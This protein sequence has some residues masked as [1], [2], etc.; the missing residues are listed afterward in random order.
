MPYSNIFFPD[1]ISNKIGNLTKNWINDINKIQHE[2]LSMVCK[3]KRMYMRRMWA[4]WAFV[5]LACI[6]Y[7]IYVKLW[8]QSI[9]LVLKSPTNPKQFRL[10]KSDHFIGCVCVFDWF[11]CQTWYIVGIF[12][13]RFWNPGEKMFTFTILHENHHHHFVHHV[14]KISSCQLLPI[15]AQ[16]YT[17]FFVH[18]PV[19]WK[20]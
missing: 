4:G 10:S 9:R 1:C 18:L 20:W 5:N 14:S 12:T 2:L 8:R 3:N 11:L 6:C 19:T 7:G 13:L 17:L 16:I 15:D